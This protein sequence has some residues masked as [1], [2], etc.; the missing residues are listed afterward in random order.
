VA[1]QTSLSSTFQHDKDVFYGLGDMEQFHDVWM[2][3]KFNDVNLSQV[4]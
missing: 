3:Q 1:P 2:V 4:D